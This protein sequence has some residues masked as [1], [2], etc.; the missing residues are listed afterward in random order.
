[1][2]QQQFVRLPFNNRLWSF[3]RTGQQWQQ[4]LID[5]QI[6]L[7]KQYADIMKKKK[8]NKK[9]EIHVFA[10]FRIGEKKLYKIVL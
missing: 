3:E 6:W 5:V 4:I 2:N 9:H 10:L 7:P 1:M 8:E